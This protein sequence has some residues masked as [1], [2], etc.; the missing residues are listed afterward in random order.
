M[1]NIKLGVKLIGGFSIV[2][3]IVLVVGFFGWQGAN[4]LNEHVDEI[5][6]VRLPSIES[7]LIIKTESNAI[8]IAL[9]SLLNPRMTMRD[10]LT[11]GMLSQG[12]ITRRETGTE[13]RRL[14][15]EVGLDADALDR[16]PHEFS[17]GQRQ[18]ICIA[19]ALSMRP[20]LIVCDEPVSSLDVSVQAQ[21]LNLL[22]DLR[23]RHG[24][25]YLFISHDLSVVRH[26]AQ[27][28]AIMYLGRLAEYGL[29]EDVMSR[30]GHPYTR[31]LLSAI[32]VPLQPPRQRMV[33]SG[34]VPSPA[35]PPPGCRFHTRCPF[36]I[37]ICRKIV[38][39]L[40][41]IDNDPATGRVVSCLRR[42]E[43]PPAE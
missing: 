1:K 24:Q 5:G 9:R 32:P 38:P 28:V 4:Q 37:D 21:V 2:A 8:R 25:A 17:G 22:M 26:I 40:E 33:S 7:L 34:D 15:G 6:M 10:I 23:E 12:M 39:E 30:P 35:A 13:A 29:V 31:M 36:A 3:L 19:R 11:E 16:Y 27:R 14:L 18:R 42:N 43:L 41:P 20:R